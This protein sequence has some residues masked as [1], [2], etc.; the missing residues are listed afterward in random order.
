MLILID[1]KSVDDLMHAQDI[2]Q[3]V[4]FVLQRLYLTTPLLIPSPLQTNQPF[5]Q[6]WRE[7]LTSSLERMIAPP[8]EVLRCFDKWL[9]FLN[10]DIES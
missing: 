3:P 4:R 7:C 2:H 8:N 10:L 1:M 6:E 9:D 5:I